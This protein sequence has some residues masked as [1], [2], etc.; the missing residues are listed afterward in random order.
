MSALSFVIFDVVS[1]E[2]NNNDIKDQLSKS[3]NIVWLFCCIGGNQQCDINH[4]A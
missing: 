1:S 4:F 3:Q 2:N